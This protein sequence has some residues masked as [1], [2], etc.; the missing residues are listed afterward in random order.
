[1]LNRK[2]VTKQIR[3]DLLRTL[4]TNACF[5]EANAPG[6]P[7]LRRVLHAV[8]YLYPAIGQSAL[9]QPR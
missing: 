1:M 4:P 5:G 3:K 7:K 8:A 6:V 9:L 2:T